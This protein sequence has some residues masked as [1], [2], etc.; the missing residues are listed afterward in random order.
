MRAAT[1]EMLFC[2]F[3]VA[4]GFVWGADPG[5]HAAEQRAV[6]ISVD[7]PDREE[8]R[9]SGEGGRCRGCALGRGL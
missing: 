4:S 2:V 5:D 3:M 9:E 8:R 7:T 6:Q 1:D